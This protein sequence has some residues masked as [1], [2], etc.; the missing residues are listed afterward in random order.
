MTAFKTKKIVTYIFI[1]VLQ[2]IMIAMYRQLYVAIIIFKNGGN[3][4]VY[5]NN[6]YDAADGICSN[7]VT[8]DAGSQDVP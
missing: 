4:Y 6:H 1:R 8:A 2:W 7:H 5:N 3:D